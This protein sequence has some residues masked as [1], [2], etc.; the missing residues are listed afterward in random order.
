M[1][2][3]SGSAALVESLNLEA[4]KHIAD[5]DDDTV[6]YLILY[7]AFIHRY[8]AV[9]PGLVY[10]GYDMALPV[11][12]ESGAHLIAVVR[13]LVH[14]DDIVHMAELAQKAHELPLLMQ[15][16]LGVW[17]ILKLAATAFTKIRARSRIF[18]RHEKA[19]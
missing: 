4:A 15:Q 17:E 2:Q 7:H 9:A 14:A 1:A 3:L 6:G 5:I 19:P 11:E 10:A 8:Y 16:L 12:T 18:I 13:R